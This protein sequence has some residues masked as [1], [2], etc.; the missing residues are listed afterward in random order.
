MVSSISDREGVGS[1]SKNAESLDSWPRTNRDIHSGHGDTSSGRAC[2]RSLNCSEDY[3]C[4]FGA[5]LR[6]LRN[7]YRLRAGA[8]SV[9]S[10]Y[11][12]IAKGGFLNHVLFLP[13]LVIACCLAGSAAAQQGSNVIQ[14]GLEAYVK[15][16]NASEAVQAW[17]KGSALEGN[18]QATSQANA[19][20]QI[21]DFYGKPES[22][23]LLGEH[24]IS[25]RARIIYFVINYSKGPAFGRMQVYKRE[26]GDWV[27]T[28]F[29][30]HTDAAQVL[31]NHL[32]LGVK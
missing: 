21:E 17:L 6:G 5:G 1:A 14:R 18:T 4:V 25:D 16:G 3:G 7:P 2:S 31:P 24:S 30:F 26:N 10:Q 28:E 29:R 23:Q 9:V 13:V 12:F 15:G 8:Q 11:F 27:S 20:R 22:Y 32:A 19:M